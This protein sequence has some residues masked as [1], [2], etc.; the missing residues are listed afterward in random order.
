MNK[1]VR[2]SSVRKRNGR[3]KREIHACGLLVYV[4]QGRHQRIHD[5]LNEEKQVYA[6]PSFRDFFNPRKAEAKTFT[7]ATFPLTE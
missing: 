7:D 3:E 5:E 1:A 4:L 6:V 2:S